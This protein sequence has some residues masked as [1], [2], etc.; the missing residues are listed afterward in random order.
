MHTFKR[1]DSLTVIVLALLSGIMMYNITTVRIGGL[2]F[3]LFGSVWT[4]A[5][6]SA[7]YV[8]RRLSLRTCLL[9]AV[10]LVSSWLVYFRANQAV[11]FI[12]VLLS[13]S[14]G[15]IALL[16]IYF[17]SIQNVS[18]LQRAAEGIC[19]PVLGMVHALPPLI[20]G[21]KSERAS[22]KLHTSINGH[23]VAGF[24]IAAAV[25]LVLVGLFS[26]SDKVFGSWFSWLGDM[27]NWL[28][29]WHIFDLVDLRTIA[30]AFWSVASIP[31][32]FALIADRPGIDRYQLRI[33][34]ESIKSV[35]TLVL[36]VM[37]GLF[38]IFSVIQIRFLFLHAALPDGYTY[39]EYARRGYG[40]L[41]V[42]T[43]FASSVLY[44]VNRDRPLKKADSRSLLT[45]TAV[46]SIAIVLISAWKR[47][48]LYEAAYGYTV[49]RMVARV[50]MVSLAVGV[51]LLV[52][53]LVGTLTARQLFGYSWWTV[54]LS[55]LL[56]IACNPAN[57][58]AARNIQTLQTR[59]TPL[60][61]NYLFS[62]GP[63]AW[64]T[65]CKQAAAIRS[66]PAALESLTYYPYANAADYAA[67]QKINATYSTTPYTYGHDY[68]MNDVSRII[69]DP[70]RDKKPGGLS[71][72]A[73]AKPQSY[74][75]LIDCLYR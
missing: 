38:A 64:D 31:F 10:A 9:L 29:N 58:I 59:E 53:Y 47:L 12:A 40:E 2:N 37:A 54:A 75:Q 16:S 30:I 68:L 70:Y 25:T 44:L 60:D 3:A 69:R 61:L 27:F 45:G 73:L 42:A 34:T 52:A 67:Q 21:L 63:D 36:G 18:Y 50:G 15:M 22:K 19:M 49:T 55:V 13:L 72:H 20:R 28:A 57:Y 74:D 48:N 51:C 26:A 17:D 11:Q 32:I 62:L 35:E 39:A 65:M 23:K 6:L 46:V 71:R 7:G 33:G 5:I 41:L 56:F 14:S 1:A 43:A 24:L 8:K 4:T 66:N